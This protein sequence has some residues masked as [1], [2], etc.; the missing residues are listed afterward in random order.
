MSRSIGSWLSKEGRSRPTRAEAPRQRENGNEGV[1]GCGFVHDSGG[2]TA[3]FAYVH[4]Y[5]S[6]AFRGTF[7]A[8]SHNRLPDLCVCD[9]PASS[10]I[11][12]SRES[13]LLAD[14]SL[15]QP[16]TQCERNG[17]LLELGIETSTLRHDRGLYL[18]SWLCKQT[19]SESATSPCSGRT[20]SFSSS[21]TVERR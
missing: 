3:I 21:S 12:C 9:S 13:H 4:A 6:C 2:S 11:P 7:E 10:A 8:I 20:K 14:L 19:V 5:F 16:R 1:A 17:L 15:R 18:H